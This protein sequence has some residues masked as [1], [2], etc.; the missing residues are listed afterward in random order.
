MK[1]ETLEIKGYVCTYDGDVFLEEK[2]QDRDHYYPDTD[3]IGSIVADHFSEIAKGVDVSLHDW[4]RG[5]MRMI[6]NVFCRYY[7]SD[8]PIEWDAI[9]EEHVKKMTGAL[10]TED[11]CAG[12]SEYTITESWTELF[13]GGHDLRN[14]LLEHKGKYVIVRIDYKI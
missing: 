3:S 1:E 11:R 10:Q 2:K 13:V 7:I 4:T 5:T 6:S 14:E 9:V 8:T 12:Y